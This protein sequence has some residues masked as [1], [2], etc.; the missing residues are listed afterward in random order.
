MAN[1]VIAGMNTMVIPDIIPGTDWGSTTLIKQVMGFAP[2][3]A[4]AST[5]ERSNFTSTEY[6]GSTMKGRKL[7][8]VPSITAPS[9]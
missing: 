6:M 2:R 3:S 1:V 4:A 7:Y 8:T 9:V 5:S